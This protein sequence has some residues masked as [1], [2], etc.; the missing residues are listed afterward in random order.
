MHVFI[1]TNI[2]LK[3]YHFTGDT[4]EAL[5]SVFVSFEKGEIHLY[6]TDQV[7]DEFNRNRELKLRDALRQFRNF[8]LA[9]N[10]PYFMKAY[11][12]YDALLVATKNFKRHAKDIQDKL[13]ADILSRSLQADELIDG[14]FQKSEL[15][16]TS[17]L[18][19]AAAVR[20]VDIGNPPGKKGSIG[21]AINWLL[22]LECV[23]DGEDLHVVSDDVDF[24]SAFSDAQA[25]P[26]LSEEWYERKR[27]RLL[28]YRNLASFFKTN[29]AE[30]EITFDPEK[31]E[32]IE[33]LGGSS[34]Y[35]DTHVI[36]SYLARYWEFSLSEAKEVLDAVANNR[37]VSDV[38]FDP[39]VESFL[40]TAIL[41]HQTKLRSAEYREYV[42]EL[43]AAQ[44]RTA[45]RDDS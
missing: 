12:E 39:D 1:D 14:I 19:Y 25:N 15:F 43:V 41:P 29:Y 17:D 5:S 10:L 45:L 35:R 27:G 31:Q 7:R 3:F 37:Q 20:R 22:L 26:F 8:S 28:I 40:C 33:Q 9:E 30:I 11:E 36:V 38:R 23:P 2:L 42:G 16:T 34:S 4:L 21:D 24:R 6:L 32:L 18:I 44:L 13:D